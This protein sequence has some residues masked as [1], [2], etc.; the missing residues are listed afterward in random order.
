MFKIIIYVHKETYKL[1]F[2]MASLKKLWKRGER[3]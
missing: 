2:F 1:K 3:S